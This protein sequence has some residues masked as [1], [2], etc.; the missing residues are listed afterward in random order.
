M[1]RSEDLHAQLSEAH[2]ADDRDHGTD[3]WRQRRHARQRDLVLSAAGI[4]ID[5]LDEAARRFVDRAASFWDVPE[6][7]GLAT[8]LVVTR[9]PVEAEP[10]SVAGRPPCLLA[11][12]EALLAAL[13]DQQLTDLA[14]ATHVLGAA[15][16]EDQQ[17]VLGYTLG[18]LIACER[19]R[20]RQLVDNARVAVDANGHEVSV[21]YD[22]VAGDRGEGWSA[23]CSCDTDLHARSEEP[24][25]VSETSARRIAGAHAADHGGRWADH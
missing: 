19:S 20:R 14:G 6:I 5:D 16:D 4:S 10:G 23:Y 11:R 13:T 24:P 12:Q 2:R 17:R 3:A 8:L 15:L 21:G 22:E 1:S 9:G 25:Y 18:I 7:V